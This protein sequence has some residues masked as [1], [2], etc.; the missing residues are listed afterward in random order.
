[1]GL[2]GSVLV[3]RSQTTLGIWMAKCAG[4]EPCTIVMDQG[5]DGR[6]RGEV[7][8]KRVALKEI[9]PPTK[10]ATARFYDHSS[11]QCVM[12]KLQGTFGFATLVNHKQFTMSQS[13]MPIE[14]TTEQDPEHFGEFQVLP[15]VYND[16]AYNGNSEIY[17]ISA[18]GYRFK[19]EFAVHIELFS[20][21]EEL[22]EVTIEADGEV[23][24]CHAR[25]V[26]VL[27][28]VG[29]Y[30]YQLLGDAW[31]NL[32][33]DIGLEPGTTVVFTKNMEHRLWVDAFEDE[34]SMIT[35]FVFKGTATL[36]RLQLPLE[37]HEETWFLKK[38][39][40]HIFNKAL[41]ILGHYREEMEIRMESHRENPTRTNHVNMHGPWS[42]VAEAGHFP[43]TKVIRFRYMS[44]RE[45]LD[46]LDG[47]NP[48]YP[49]FQIC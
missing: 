23:Y 48:Y 9:L 37:W 17:V 27:G 46:V 29:A 3:F 4:I 39:P 14:F 42:Q 33:D 12:L 36:N 20:E 6:K 22:H 49:I 19:V 13:K 25:R 26:A 21:L 43:Y 1:M 40:M 31:N 45:D 30:K 28:V 35:D 41:I 10:F 2:Q 44:N 16:E 47:Q 7:F 8:L 15:D 34:G 5:S 18:D 24:P 38:H 11:N 32:V